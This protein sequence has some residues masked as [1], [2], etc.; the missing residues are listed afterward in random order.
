MSESPSIYVADLAAYNNGLL[1]GVWID[2]TENLDGIKNKI[3]EMLA[4]SPIESAE[5]YAIHDYENFG[6]YRVGEYEG[7]ESVCE[8][9]DFVAVYPEFGAE[10]LNYFGNVDESRQ[11]AE[12]NYCGCYETVAEYAQETIEETSEI[13]QHLASYIDYRAMARDWEL[14]GDLLTFET[15]YKE[16]HVFYSR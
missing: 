11:M 9:A 12:D 16:V 7:I 3:Q 2:A 15:G 8:I 1:R 14:S 13:P 10:L 4:D 5:E 6:G